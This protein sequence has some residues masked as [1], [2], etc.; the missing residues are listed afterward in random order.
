MANGTVKAGVIGWPIGHSLS[1]L[2]NAHW[3]RKFGVSGSYDHLPCPDDDAAFAALLTELRTD[4]YDGANVT[5]PHKARAARLADATSDTVK[6]LGVANTL[7]FTPGGVYADNTD[8]TG[9]EAALRGALA[10]DENPQRALVLGAG[11]AA[12]AICLALSRIGC[13]QIE[14]TNRTSQK[15]EALSGKLHFVTGT[16]DWDRFRNVI[17]DYDIIVNTTSLGMKGQPPLDLDFTASPGSQV[18]ADIIYTPLQT[19]L[20]TGAAARGLR[21]LNGLD[22][23]MHQAVPGFTRWTGVTPHVD[24]GLRQVLEARL[25][26]E[27]RPV[28]IGLTGSIGMGKST[29]TAMFGEHGAATWNAD[30]AVHRLY[31]QDGLA[32]EPVGE[33][34]PGVIKDGA[35]SRA[36][37]SAHLLKHPDDYADLEAIVHP[38]VALDRQRFLA[39]ARSGGSLACVMDVPLLFENGMEEDFDTVIAVTAT[40]A[41]QRERVL[42]RKGMTEEKFQSILARQT[43]D[44]DKRARADYIIDTDL[45]MDETRRQVRVVWR[46]ILEKFVY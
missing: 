40:E 9:F 17:G 13:T 37:L 41:V 43:P 35:V 14:V 38:L 39:E 24:A 46:D 21:T 12:P 23:L 6:M 34:F 8:V 20:L 18:V 3:R 36:S 31:A 11:G 28:A 16:V 45:P 15:A 27:Q 30:D 44:R 29:V 32:V 42:A 5:L 7:S 4:G 2:V 10:S 26:G 33:R 25:C 22:M 19:P 1:P